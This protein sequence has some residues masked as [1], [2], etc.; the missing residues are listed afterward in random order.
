MEPGRHATGEEQDMRVIR[1]AETR[2]RRQGNIGRG[3]ITSREVQ[4]RRHAGPYAER[5][6]QSLTSANSPVGE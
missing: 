4:H 5:V 1:D 6:I 2:R 3:S